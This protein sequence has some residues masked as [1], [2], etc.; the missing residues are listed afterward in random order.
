MV[1]IVTHP[2][3]NEQLQRRLDDLARWVES[4]CYVQVTAGSYTGLFGKAAKRCATELMRLPQVLDAVAVTSFGPGQAEVV[5]ASGRP[6]QP[7]PAEDLP[8][9][10]LLEG[11][12]VLVIGRP[13]NARGSQRK[14]DRQEARAGREPGA[15]G[16]CAHA[17]CPLY[18]GRESS[19]AVAPTRG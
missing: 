2:E 7:D 3:R 8:D 6:V 18:P 10:P 14:R 4:G 13:G 1:P 16:P 11:I 5:T 17:R 15:P 9:D 12:V 19:S